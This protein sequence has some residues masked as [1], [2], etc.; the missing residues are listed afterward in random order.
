MIISK[1]LTKTKIWTITAFTVLCVVWLSLQSIFSNASEDNELPEADR[2]AMSDVYSFVQQHDTPG[3]VVEYLESIMQKNTENDRVQN[4]LWA[5]VDDFVS[6]NDEKLTEIEDDTSRINSRL[7]DVLVT[8]NKRREEKQQEL[9]ILD[10]DVISQADTASPPDHLAKTMRDDDNLEDLDPAPKDKAIE[11]PKSKENESDTATSKIDTVSDTKV[12][13]YTQEVTRPSLPTQD[14][15]QK[16]TKLVTEWVYDEHAVEQA[17]LWW[18]NVLRAER[19]LEL[20]TTDFALRETA[21]DWSISLRQKQEADHKRS[22]DAVY[23]DYPVITEWFAD[24]GVV[25]AN[26]DWAT[27]TEN[28]WRARHTC[29][30]VKPG[31]DCTQEVIADLRRIFD[32]FAAEESYNGVHWRT[33][34]HPNFR[35]VWVSFAPDADDD[36]V[37]AVMHYGTEVVE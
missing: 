1:Y 28:I 5:V 12:L 8:L 11:V 18:V 21:R 26:H 32:Y 33:M 6:Q 34:I 25:F 20:M 35:V 19:W 15:D 14:F 7:E 22:P 31:E 37:Y 24:R 29:P 4:I 23:Y 13:E 16:F 3:E 9:D 27:S 17:R 30:W 36:K 2:Q 10:I